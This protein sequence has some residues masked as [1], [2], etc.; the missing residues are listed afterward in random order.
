MNEAKCIRTSKDGYCII[1]AWRIGMEDTG[2]LAVPSRDGLLQMCK[3]E[4][5]NKL[6]DYLQFI[7]SSFE[8]DKQVVDALEKYIDTGDFSNNIIDMII[9]ALSNCTKVAAMCYV[10]DTSGEYIPY[11][12][13][14]I[15]KPWNGNVL[16]HINLLKNGSNGEHYDV[17]VSFYS[18]VE[19]NWKS[20]TSKRRH[21]KNR[22]SVLSDLDD[23]N[24]GSG[25][26]KVVDELEKG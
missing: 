19:D 21:C 3:N 17:L 24:P 8:H 25:S 6:K 7:D 14:V 13:D 18:F 15:G 10:E 26:P 4:I 9:P 12:N 2:T 22:Y 11:Q 23:N 5:L 16:Y 20:N 1:E